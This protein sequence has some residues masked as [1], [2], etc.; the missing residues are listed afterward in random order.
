M[1]IQKTTLNISG[2][3][4]ASCAVS[5]EKELLKTKGILDASVNFAAKKVYV[6]YDADVLGEEDVRQVIRD[7]GYKIIEHGAWNMEHKK[8][9]EEIHHEGHKAEMMEDG[10]HQH[11]GEDIQKNWNAF[12]WSAVLSVPLL[13]EMIHKFRSEI[14]FGGLDAVMWLH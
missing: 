14:F 3:S 8:H 13:V 10:E 5:N 7:N 1:N 2:M 12:L 11:G 6:E 9:G 4:C